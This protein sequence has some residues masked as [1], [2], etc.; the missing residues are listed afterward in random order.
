MS[1]LAN[2]PFLANLDAADLKNLAARMEERA[3]E[4]G[5][6]IYAEGTPGEGLYY[7]ASGTVT[8]LTGASCD[9]EIM[10][11]LPK[12]STLGESALLNDHPRVNAA[13]AA[14][15]C[16]I[17]V[18]SRAD[19]QVFLAEHPSAGQTVTQTLMQRPPRGARQLAAELLKPMPIFKGIADDGMLAIARKLQP[20]QF[21]ANSVIFLEGQNPDAMYLVETGDVSLLSSA[22]SGQQ[23]IAEIGAHDFFGEDALL[24]D[25]P[26]QIAAIA[27]QAADLWTLNRSD[28]DALVSTH[29]AA[30]LALTRA[31]AARSER[32]NRQ[33]LTITAG[34]AV[35]AQRTAAPAAFAP[36]APVAARPAAI[37]RPVIYRQPFI[38]GFRSWLSGLP[39]AG[40]LR[41]A[42]VAVLLAWLLAVSIPTA[43]AR[44]M[45]GTSQAPAFALR[46]AALVAPSSRG[47]AQ[48]RG[49]AAA[50]LVAPVAEI[51]SDA[52][53]APLA[54]MSE[55]VTVKAAAVA[56]AVAAASAPVAAAPVAAVAAP[57]VAAKYGVAAGDTLSQIASE[58]NVPMNV[59][60]EA[61]NI[62]DPALIHVGQELVIPGG[63]EQTAIAA[64]LA[65]APR[66][67]A[68][69]VPVAVAPAAVAAAA[70]AAPAAPSAP[71][72]PFT[73]DG[74]MDK[75]GV[76][77]EAAAVAPGQP[78][79]RLVKAIFRD[80]NEAIGPN[81]PG[82]DH[83]I[84]VEVLDENG[85]REIGAK[86][87]VR[88][89]GAATLLIENKPFPEFAANFP[90]YGM[91]GS[92]STWVDNLPSDKVIGMGLP[93]KWHVTF[94]LT[95]QKTI[96]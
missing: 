15:E 12:G 75:F 88:N 2:V 45:S 86:A 52:A 32:L 64:K 84:Y 65:A 57:A 58:F 35:P 28:F 55:I 89:G 25:Q 4:A 33:L 9:G 20:G 34:T 77:M 60:A 70:P 42:V 91:M 90:M 14:T 29:P 37:A 49:A 8:I 73:W 26:R 95:F 51:V 63:A 76:H 68:K 50:E 80:T 48:P 72:L 39:T 40:K 43:I 46:G 21:C 11:H 3:Y 10:A 47:A 67:T 59:L 62:S 13:R 30:V 7:V 16:T 1:E 79:Y 18:L 17:L 69:P 56:P 85:K 27:R 22:A 92:Y 61:N 87:T 81:L 36:L 78:Y 94:F 24:T 66:P 96:K 44:G 41:L 54:R 93:M 38:A 31:L 82:G 53:D 83:N 19:F 74:R 23:V 6:L 71:A 5:D